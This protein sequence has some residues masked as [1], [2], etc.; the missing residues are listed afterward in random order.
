MG[1]TARVLRLERVA[2]PADDTRIGVVNERDLPDAK[3]DAVTVW[4]GG[5]LV[6]VVTFRERYPGAVLVVRRSFSRAA[7]NVEAARW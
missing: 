1:L 5:T 3:L 6:S 4:P 7:S 2:R